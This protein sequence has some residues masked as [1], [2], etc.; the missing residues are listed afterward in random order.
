MRS[1]RLLPL[2]RIRHGIGRQPLAKAHLR[3]QQEIRF[4]SRH[5]RGQTLQRVIQV[6]RAAVDLTDGNLH[7]VSTPFSSQRLQA[8]HRLP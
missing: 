4:L 7:G 2:A 5:M 8:W 1:Y 3:H 6:I